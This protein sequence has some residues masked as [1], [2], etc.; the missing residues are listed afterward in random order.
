MRSSTEVYLRKR[1]SAGGS[2]DRS[3]KRKYSDTN[4]SSP[5]KPAAPAELGAPACNDSAARYRPAGQ[6]SV[7]SVSS[8]SSPASTSTP[9]ASS[10]SPASARP[11]GGPPRRSRPP[12]RAPAS[13]RAAARD[14]PCWRPRSASRPERNRTAPPAR[15][16]R[17]GLATA[18]RSSSTSTSGRSSAASARPTRGT[19]FAQVDPPGPDNAS[20]TS[21]GTGSTLWI[22]AAMYRRNTTASSSRPSSAT[23]ANGRESASAHCA[24]SV[25][26]PYPAGATTLTN[27]T[28]DV[29]SR[30][31]TSAFA[32]VPGLANGA[33]S[34]ISKTS[35]GTSARAMRDRPYGVRK[36]PEITLLV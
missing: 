2:R 26:L 35:N 13:G 12:D 30:A 23:H 28:V 36:R 25:V 17:T 20:K 14:L 10:S 16:G 9:A 29:Q 21:G 5:L 19:R 7:R 6:P 8:E 1:A 3:S 24:R 34:L 32:T 18:C 27:G 15:P 22:A 33:A 11:A 31:I 4:R